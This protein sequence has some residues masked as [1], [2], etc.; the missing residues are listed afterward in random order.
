MSELARNR[1]LSADAGCAL[2]HIGDPPMIAGRCTL[3]HLNVEAIAVVLDPQP[4]ARAV[5]IETDEDITG[6]AVPDSITDGLLGDTQQMLYD[7]GRHN[8][9]RPPTA[10]RTRTGSATMVSS[11]IS[12]RASGRL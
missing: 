4:H 9:A 8:R 10:M 12:R 5:V 3:H 2:A 11:A 6:A 1:K 7:I